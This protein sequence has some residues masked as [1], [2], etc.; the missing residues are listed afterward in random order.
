MLSLT[1]E[2]IFLTLKLTI[3][4]YYP[5]TFF[6]IYEE[7]LSQRCSERSLFFYLILILSTIGQ[8]SADFSYRSKDSL[9][10]TNKT[11]FGKAIITYYLDDQTFPGIT[12]FSL[13]TFIFHKATSMIFVKCQFEHSTIFLKISNAYSL[14]TE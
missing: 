13:W 8:Y 3:N 11:A 12:I 4:C 9:F 6:V 1:P 14:S 2:L 10:L 7:A 5:Y